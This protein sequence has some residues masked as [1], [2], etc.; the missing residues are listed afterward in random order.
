MCVLK[1]LR[2]VSLKLQLTFIHHIGNFEAAVYLREFSKIHRETDYS[3]IS[4]DERLTIDGSRKDELGAQSILNRRAVIYQLNPLPILTFQ[5]SDI[6]QRIS[7]SVPEH[8]TDGQ[9][10]FLIRAVGGDRDDDIVAEIA[11]DEGA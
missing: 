5:V 8:L 1:T 10:S 9:L 2:R 6:L 7:V 4:V 11:I 3:T